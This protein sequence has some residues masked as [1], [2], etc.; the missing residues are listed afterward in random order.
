MTKIIFTWRYFLALIVTIAILITSYLA[1]HS[2]VFSLDSKHFNEFIEQ[3]GA[4]APL[5]MIGLIA[6]EVVIAP[7]PGGWLAIA[8]GFMFGSWLGFVYAY[9]GNIIGATIAFELARGLGQ[10]FVRRL[11]S[12]KAYERYSAKLGTSLFGLGLLYAIPLFP[13]D[14]I[15]L[16]LGMTAIRRKDYYLVS[17]VGFIPNMLVL[18]FIGAGIAQPNYRYTMI[19]LVAVALAY[20]VWKAFR[21]RLRPTHSSTTTPR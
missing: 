7:L 14:I 21:L 5:V 1:L 9:A 15:S 20:F 10:P 16:L 18:N 13:I 2:V 11:V 17:A 4:A 12:E 8:T 19:A 3:F 6:A